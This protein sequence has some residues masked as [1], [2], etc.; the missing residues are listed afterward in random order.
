MTAF[1]IPG[2]VS[3]S[4]RLVPIVREHGQEADAWHMG[5]CR[6]VRSRTPHLKDGLTRLQLTVSH[7]HRYPTW[8]EI[9]HARYAL[10]PM[11]RCYALLLP[12][13]DSYVDV[14]YQPFT[15]QVSEVRDDGE[16][17]NEPS[18]LGRVA[19]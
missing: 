11:E 4:F 16:P 1:G 6:I 18:S 2:T 17:W 7:P 14:P 9:K 3:P 8:D 15:F 5:E 13:P 10:L 19:P 12:P